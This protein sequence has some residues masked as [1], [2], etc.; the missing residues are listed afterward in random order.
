MT[1]EEEFDLPDLTPAAHTKAKKPS[2]SLRNWVISLVICGVLGFLLFKAV[3]GAS[4]F[5]LNVDEAVAQREELGADTFRMQGVVL[6]ETGGEGTA[7]DLTFTVGYN[8]TTAQVTHVG[9][10]PTELFECGQNVIVEGTWIGERFQSR[11]IVVKH[12][13]EYLEE[14]PDRAEEI[15]EIDKCSALPYETDS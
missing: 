5:Y 3:T 8:N 13:E 10:E 4:V 11:Q 14:N 7:Q 12:S 2:R 1:D 15:N 6:A 9:E